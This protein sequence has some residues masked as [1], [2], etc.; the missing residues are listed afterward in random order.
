MTLL[1]SVGA[2]LLYLAVHLLHLVEG[3]AYR[4]LK[5]RPPVVGEVPRE[6]HHFLKEQARVLQ[7][8]ITE[9]PPSAD[10]SPVPVCRSS[11]HPTSN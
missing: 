5:A 1:A 10:A 6:A 8:R 3:L 9:T 2:Q 7:L 4:C 11:S